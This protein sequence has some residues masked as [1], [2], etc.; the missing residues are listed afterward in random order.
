MSGAAFIAVDW[1]TTNRRTYL[2]EGADVVATER[3]EMGILSIPAGGF[4]KAVAALR[5]RHGG[6][7]MLLAGMVGSN[8]G[9][10]D[11]GYV[12]APA[13]LPDL[14]AH[15]VSP[16]DGIAI[17]PG[18]CRDVGRRQDV[19]RGEEVQLLGAIEAGL[20]PADALLCQPGTHAKWATM[21]GGTL[22]DFTTAMT[23]EMFALLKAHA[24]IGGE[25]AGE[26][27]AD[28][29]FCEGVAACA[30]EDLLAALFG[31]RAAS[32]LG[33]RAPGTAAAYVS[34]LLIGSDCRARI[35]QPGQR[36]HLLANGLLARLY[37]AAIAIAGGEAVL[38]DSH[39]AF[40]AG[41]TRIWDIKS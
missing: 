8:R 41:I 14:A 10:H 21:E 40:V 13:A 27:D 5:A 2:I 37:S 38:V 36:V 31:V 22:A 33:R 29:A 25:M 35:T 39:A 17:V 20:A 15:L 3:D 6:L 18:V 23:G 16:L 26:V 1:G 11:A 9:W 19:M 30:D 7:P 32:I 34:G 12:P 28:D 4:P 24:L